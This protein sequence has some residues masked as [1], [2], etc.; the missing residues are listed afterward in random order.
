MSIEEREWL[1]NVDAMQSQEVVSL[2]RSYTLSMRRPSGFTIH[3]RA[4]KHRTN[5]SKSSS[6]SIVDAEQSPTREDI[7]HP[8]YPI[9]HTHT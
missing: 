7:M 5:G 8:P 1:P 3:K 4:I 2:F 6:F 9:P